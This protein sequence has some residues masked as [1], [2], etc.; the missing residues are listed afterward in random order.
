M[1]HV[2]TDVFNFDAQ[3][4]WHE[5]GL[6]KNITLSSNEVSQAIE[7]PLLEIVQLIKTLLRDTPAE[8]SADIMDKGMI[9]SGGVA[10]MRNIDQYISQSIGVP[11][12]IADDPLLCVARGTGIVLD[13]L[14]AYKHSLMSKK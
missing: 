13:N 1:Y 4:F 7:E 11:C 5:N 6:P 2:L 10:L 8:L 12:F 14:D 9:I 3:Y